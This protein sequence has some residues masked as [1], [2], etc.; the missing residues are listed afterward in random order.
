MSVFAQNQLAFRHLSVKDGLSQGSVFCITQDHTGFI[1]LGT[2]DGLNKFDGYSF[3]AYRN[4]PKDPESISHSDVRSLCPDDTLLWVGTIEGLNQYHEKTD[5][6]RRYL[7][8]PENEGSLSHSEIRT[9]YRDKQGRIWVGTPNGLNLYDRQRDAFIRILHD[10]DNPLSISHPTVSCIG[11]DAQGNLWVGTLDGLNLLVKQE[12]DKFVF[13]RYFHQ[14]T[15]PYSLSES[16]I[17]A[18]HTDRQGTLWIGTHG[19]GLNKLDTGSGQFTHYLFEAGN[20]HSLTHNNVRALESDPAG[21]LWVGTLWGLNRFD[22][23]KQTFERHLNQGIGNQSL[24]NNSIKSLF[25]DKK[26]SLWIGTFFGGV[27]FLDEL[28]NRFVNY[29]H[30]PHINSLIYNVVSSFV[31]DKKGNFWIGTEGG[32]LNYFD[33]T[34][35]HFSVFQYLPRKS[36]GLKGENI[37]KLLDGGDGSLWIGT[38]GNGLIQYY[39]ETERFRHYHREG[40]AEHRLTNDNVYAL[41]KVENGMWIGTYGGGLHKLEG[42]NV[43]GDHYVNREEDTTSLVS[44]EVRALLLDSSQR[45]WI[46]TED[47]LDRMEKDESGKIHFIHVLKKIGIFCLY[48]DLFGQL[49]AGTYGGGLVKINLKNGD[50][51]RFT[52]KDGLPGNII[53]GIM[54]D[55]SGNLW[56]STNNGISRYHPG[57]QKFN[58]YSLADGLQNLEFNFNAYMKTRKGEMVFGGANG[59]TL[60]HPGTIIPNDYIPPIAFTVLQVFNQP[61]GIGENEFFHLDHSL[62]HTQHLTFRYDQ[63]IFSISFSALN[64][65]SPENNRYAWRLEGLETHWNYATGK[66]AASYSIQEAGTYTLKVR[67]SNNDGRW[68]PEVKSLKITV[69]PPPWKSWWAFILYGLLVLSAVI[70]LIRFT[71]LRAQFRHQIQLEQVEKHKQEE[72]HQMKLRFFTNITH[73]FRTPLTLILGPLEEILAQYSHDPWIGNQISSVRRNAQRLLNLVNQLLMFRKMEK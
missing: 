9:I 17:Q 23:Q 33:R 49:W 60:F 3:T 69:L 14:D 71:R 36:Q 54:E 28:N 20:P 48:E 61:V 42:E 34:S 37:K 13:R 65:V 47:G 21:N 53:M 16:Y 73:E 7:H 29:Q 30:S 31:E 64:Y 2:R 6:F 11:E 56:L 68:N 45:L 1:W 51:T 25:R 41:L 67:G 5:R 10:P 15:D 70:A 12:E 57:E 44:D 24:G 63:A 59:F 39:P 72:I 66:T 27:S 26:G 22:P 43:S 18:I 38:F 58:N 46:G 35:N 55:E 62:N 4:S 52:M 32:G 19:A 40:I 8:E 50:V